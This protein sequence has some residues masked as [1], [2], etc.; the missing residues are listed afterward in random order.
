[1]VTNKFLWGPI[2]R[3]LYIGLIWGMMLIG[4]IMPDHLFWYIP[5][6][7]FLGFGLRPFLERSGLYDLFFHFRE[8]FETWRWKKFTAMRHREIRQKQ[9]DAKYRNRRVKDPK[10]AKN[11]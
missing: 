7:L 1:M 8:I 10:L 11:W 9:R 3:G 5:M 6:M 2:A 4:T